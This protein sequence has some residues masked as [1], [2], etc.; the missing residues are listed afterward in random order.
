MIDVKW[1]YILTPKQGRIQLWD[2]IFAIKHKFML[3]F[4]FY[5]LQRMTERKRLIENYA[6][7]D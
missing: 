6:H 3:S 1:H 5:F 2:I 7:Y 4:F